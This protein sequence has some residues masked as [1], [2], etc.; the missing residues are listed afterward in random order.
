MVYHLLPEHL[1]WLTPFSV[2]PLL[3]L[4]LL[5]FAALSAVLLL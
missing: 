3:L 2:L 1:A 4:L 5:L